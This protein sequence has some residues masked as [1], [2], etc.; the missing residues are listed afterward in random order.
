MPLYRRWLVALGPAVWDR[1]IRSRFQQGVERFGGKRDK[2][3]RDARHSATREAS[4][5][6]LGVF[7]GHLANKRKVL[8]EVRAVIMAFARDK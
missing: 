3:D 8:A 6:S 7:H 2:M 5:E 1:H 4:E